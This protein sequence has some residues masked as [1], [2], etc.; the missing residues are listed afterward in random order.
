MLMRHEAPPWVLT[1]LWSMSWWW[2]NK[3]N[4]AGDGKQKRFRYCDS[5]KLSRGDWYFPLM[6]PWIAEQ[7]NLLGAFQELP[8]DELLSILKLLSMKPEWNSMIILYQSFCI[9]SK[10]LW[11]RKIPTMANSPVI[12]L[13]RQDLSRQT[14]FFILHLRLMLIS[15]HWLLMISQSLREKR[16]KERR[17]IGFVFW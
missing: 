16:R 6:H 5:C 10:K 14:I 2:S 9:S 1:S 11:N 12:S 17:Q 8:P 3:C 7:D 15:G 4:R 13:R